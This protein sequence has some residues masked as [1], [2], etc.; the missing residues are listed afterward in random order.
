MFSRNI[1]YE[2]SMSSF[3]TG[4]ECPF[5]LQQRNKEAFV[6]L[7]E[8]GAEMKLRRM[9][10]PSKVLSAMVHQQFVTNEI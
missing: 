1:F 5:H 3:A 10:T 6:L 9:M 4:M 2:N 7:E 8:R